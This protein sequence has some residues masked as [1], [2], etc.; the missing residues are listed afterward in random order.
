MSR[1]T[2]PCSLYIVIRLL[3]GPYTEEVYTA[4]RTSA[5]SP[6]CPARIV[7]FWA[8]AHDLWPSAD[9]SSGQN[10]RAAGNGTLLEVITKP[11]GKRWRHSPESLRHAGQGTSTEYASR[12]PAVGKKRDD[13][14]EVILEST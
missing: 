10:N 7:H 1:N 5:P 2:L 12:C 14:H 6:L 13:K 11:L 4:G 9:V 3:S 8:L